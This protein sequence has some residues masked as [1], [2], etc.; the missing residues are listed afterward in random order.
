M[1]SPIAAGINQLSGATGALGLDL[2]GT[3]ARAKEDMRKN[4]EETF[5]YWDKARAEDARKL[6]STKSTTPNTTKTE[7]T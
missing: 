7:I 3:R 6:D 1:C 2:F 4:R 5:K